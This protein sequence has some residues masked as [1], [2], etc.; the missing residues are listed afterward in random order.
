[1]LEFE[2]TKKN[3]GIVLW[4]DTWALHAVHDLV[5]KINEASPIIKNKEGYMLGL[6]YDVRK[7]FEGMRRK[8]VRVRF[9][10]KCPIYGVE[11]MWPVLIAQV[12]LLRASM[13]FVPTGRLDQAIMFELE[14]LVETAAT[15]AFSDNADQIM[16]EMNRIGSAQD[17]AETVLDSRSQYFISLA[18]K[19]RLKQ[20]PML[21]A[22]FDPMYSYVAEIWAQNGVKNVIPVSAFEQF[23]SSSE[24][25]HFQ[26]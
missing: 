6:A 7:A 23:S 1:M 14:H 5:H 25:P 10:D 12:G 9:E 15:S 11:I 2:L 22:S 16:Y 8:D 26:W 21:L 20:F 13:G 17:H 24:W 4:G 3:A 19:E 18:P